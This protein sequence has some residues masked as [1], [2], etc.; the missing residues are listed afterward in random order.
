MRYKF[1]VSWLIGLIRAIVPRTESVMIES[2]LLAFNKNKSVVR[3][4]WIFE[5]ISIVGIGYPL[6]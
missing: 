3:E 6:V 2:I 5:I 1:D 4:Y